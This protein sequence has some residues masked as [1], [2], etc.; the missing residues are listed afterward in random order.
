MT[1]S[2]KIL[3][4]HNYIYS[5]VNALIQWA[6]LYFND[7]NFSI[8]NE[9]KSNYAYLNQYYYY[10][11]ETEDI[12]KIQY[13]YLDEEGYNS[14]IDDMEDINNTK[15]YLINA[16]NFEPFE[17]DLIVDE[18]EDNSDYIDNIENEEYDEYKEKIKKF[19][20]IKKDIKQFIHMNDRNRENEKKFYEF[21]KLV[22]SFYAKI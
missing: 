18:V 9:V 3:E 19:S 8:S 7:E 16:V 14:D 4:L 11:K 10:T 13:I 15:K 22:V 5:Y 2:G 20:T 21:N 17:T 6:K 12:K 1:N